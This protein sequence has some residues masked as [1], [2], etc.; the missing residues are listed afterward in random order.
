MRKSVVTPAV[1]ILT[2][3]FVCVGSFISS[4]ATA[5]EEAK[6]G[7]PLRFLFVAP[8]VN[9]EFFNPVKKGMRDAAEMV[10]AECEFIGTED[11]DVG[12]QSGM[13]QKG[14]DE[15]YDGIA[16]LI[17]DATGFEKSFTAARK[18]G[19]PVV[20]FNA[21]G[22]TDKSLRLSAVCQNLYQAGRSVGREAA[23]KLPQGCTVLYTQHS[24]GISALDDRLRGIQEELKKKGITGKVVVTGTTPEESKEVIEKALRADPTI[25]AVLATGQADTEGAGLAVEESFPNRGLYV[26]GFDLAPNTLRLIKKG[27]VDFTVDQQPYAQGYYP[28]IQLALFCRYGIRPS[29]MDTGATIIRAANV[30]RVLKLSKA[31]YR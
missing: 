16:V 4:P 29:D 2:H 11:V 25:K 7:R 15:A 27:V 20:A 9:E 24:A 13:V 23:A 18:K 26:A 6:S 31:G 1:L 12:V 22:G 28:V 30:D 14:V 3:L 5:A 19:I 8:C 21:D 17:I 10:G